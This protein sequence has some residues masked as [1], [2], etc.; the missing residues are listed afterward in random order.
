MFG[1]DSMPTTFTLNE[2]VPLAQALAAR[3]AISRNIRTLAIKGPVFEAHGLRP[4]RV[5]T[6]ADIMVDP[7]RFE[8]FCAAMIESGWRERFIREMP[9]VLPLHSRTFLHPEWPCDIDA[10][11]YYPGFFGDVQQTFEEMWRSRVHIEVA[12]SLVPAQ[13][14]AGSAVIG[15]LHALRHPRSPRH[16][17]EHRH[18]VQ[19]VSRALDAGEREDILRLV[20]VGRAKEV[21]S[22][23]LHAL[24]LGESSY[25][26]SPSERRQWAFYRETHDD[27]ATGAWLM[28]VRRAPWYAKPVLIAR[29]LF[30]TAE[31][32]RKTLPSPGISRREVWTYRR[33]RW[34][35]GRVAIT[36]AW[37]ASRAGKGNGLETGGA[38]PDGDSHAGRVDHQPGLYDVAL[39]ESER[40]R[41]DQ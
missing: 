5:S 2:A 1:H 3:I 13:S 9:H 38:T 39:Q 35:R 41:G 19:A 8:E 32:I 23:F 24:Q 25:D 30:P 27:G 17:E 33:A 34:N 14:R 10:H 31:E 29:A 6:D 26:L 4:I 22:T 18:I 11:Y 15:A 37:A 12:H 36:R 16:A 20:E 7:A 28:A 40:M 21:L